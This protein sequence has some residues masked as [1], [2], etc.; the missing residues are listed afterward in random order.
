MTMG[1]RG[2]SIFNIAAEKWW[3]EGYFPI[4]ARELFRGELLN[5]GGGDLHRCF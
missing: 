4:G 3:L 5:F 2:Y 1:E